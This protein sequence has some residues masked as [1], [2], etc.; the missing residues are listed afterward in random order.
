MTLSYINLPVENKN[1]LQ[2]ILQKL[3]ADKYF[4]DLNR[5][6]GDV[7]GKA[8]LTLFFGL[9]FEKLD[10]KEIE[11]D[12][13]FVSQNLKSAEIVDLEIFNLKDA[14]CNAL[15]AILKDEGKISK[16]HEIFKKYPHDKKRPAPF[17]AHVTLAY[18]SRGYKLPYDLTLPKLT[19]YFENAELKIFGARKKAGA[20]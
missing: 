12:L 2:E 10:K 14:P 6:G 7:T 4:C 20:P 5:K 8:H 3:S 1:D 16:L 19:V 9:I 15:V 13:Q 17:K 18:V 11:K